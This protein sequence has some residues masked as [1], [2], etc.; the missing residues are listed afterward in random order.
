MERV[1]V[2]V[3]ILEME[4]RTEYLE[5]MAAVSPRL[6]IKHHTCSTYDEV[7][8]ALKDVE[9]LYTH[10]SPSH[11]N[12]AN[13]LRWVTLHYAG[14]DSDLS[15]PIF[16]ARRRVVVTNVSGAH[17]IP[18]AEYAI[19]T[20]V[21]LARNFMQLVRDKQERVYNSDHSSPTELP[22]QTV[23]IAG[24]GHIG[25]ELGRLAQAHGMR[26]LAMKRDPTERRATG[27]QWEGVGD[28]DGTL[29]E[30]CYGMDDMFEMLRE[31]DFV[32]NC[33][34]L[35]RETR[36]LFGNRAFAAMK[37][38]AYF[39][40]IGRGATVQVDALTRAL[41]DGAIAGAALDDLEKGPSAADSPLWELGNVFISPHISGTRRNTQ[42]LE[43]TNELF[44]EN[45]RRYLNREPLVNEVTRERGY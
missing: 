37:P 30:R 32:V 2:L 11:L 42:Y 24:Y 1:R 27:Y 4:G 13:K 44:C 16:E 22:G 45:L 10:R 39:I 38:G 41:R 34:P 6:E 12:D 9:V 29:P 8:N 19:A 17:S 40:N 20:M 33:L 15:S 26:I 3:T 23:G 35:T 7:A 31:S 43:R 18:I 5:Q 14:I 36:A 28:P 21:L 25:R